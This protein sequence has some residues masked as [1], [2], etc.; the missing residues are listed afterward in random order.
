MK[1]GSRV[2]SLFDGPML[3]PHRIEQ[4]R[5]LT[6]HGLHRGSGYEPEARR[7]VLGFTPRPLK[8]R[9]P[10]SSPDCIC[11][12]IRSTQHRH[13][14]EFLQR[15]SMIKYFWFCFLSYRCSDAAEAEGTFCNAT[16]RAG[17]TPASSRMR[18]N[19]GWQSYSTG[20]RKR[21]STNVPV[22]AAGALGRRRI[23]TSEAASTASNELSCCPAGSTKSLPS[24]SKCAFPRR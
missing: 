22:W 23:K 15:L 8:A 21:Q 17:F 18:I 11:E 24:P 16:K 3:Y 12:S 4:T 14:T 9:P 6:G 1:N 7:H 2:P 19:R 10:A 5:R 13:M 20:R